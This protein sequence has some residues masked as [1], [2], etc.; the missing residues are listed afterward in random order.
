MTRLFSIAE[1]GKSDTPEGF[2]LW[3]I[4]NELE[5]LD[6]KQATFSREDAAALRRARDTINAM[7]LRVEQ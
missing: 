3:H 4:E 7:L 2:D 5:E 1:F 6:R